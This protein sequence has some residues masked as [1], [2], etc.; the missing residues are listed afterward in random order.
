TRVMARKTSFYYS[1]LVLPPG[2]RRA[3]VA[4]WDFCRAVDDAVDEAPRVEGVGG[5]LPAGRQAVRFWRDEL[6]R[7][8]DGRTPSTDQGRRRARAGV[9]AARGS[10]RA[11]LRRR[12]S[13]R[14]RRDRTGPAPHRVR[15]PP[16][17][18]LL[19]AREGRAAPRRSQAARRR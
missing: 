11:R 3:I 7:A 9:P 16:R 8:F 19:Q 14:R 5:G 10:A 1:F 4:V 18:G 15:V 13:C 17:A 12:G 2:E 6:A